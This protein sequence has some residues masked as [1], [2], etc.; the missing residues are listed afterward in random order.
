[1]NQQ[2]KTIPIRGG[3]FLAL[4]AA[5][6]SLQAGTATFDLNTDPATGTNTFVLTGNAMW[7]PTGGNPGGFLR[8]TEAVDSQRSAILFPDIDQGRIVKAFNFSMDVRSGD[9]EGERAADGFSIN[10]ARAEDPIIEGII[11]GGTGPFAGSQDNGGNELDLPEEGTQTG[12]GIG[13]DTWSGNG[14]PGSR[15][16]EGISIR[17][18][19]QQVA[20]FPLPTRHGSVDDPTSLQTGPRSTTGEH[21][22]ETL[23]WARLRVEL[24]EMGQLSVF[25]KGAQLLTNYQ[26]SYFPSAGR[27][28]FGGRTGGENEIADVDNIE[29]TTIPVET[30]DTTPPT[31]P[32]N[33]V[34]LPGAYR[35]LLTWEPSTD[36]ESRVAYTIEK[37][38]TVLPSTIVTNVFEDFQVSP[39]S[40]YTYRIRA[41]DLAA[42]TSDWAS[43][44]ANTIAPVSQLGFV[45][46]EIYQNIPGTLVD[47]LL[48]DPEFQAGTPDR[49]VYLPGLSFGEW[50]GFGDTYGD[51]YGISLSGTLTVP[52]TGQYNFFIRSDDASRL[53]LNT[54]GAALPDPNTATPIAEETDCCDPFVEP[55]ELNDDAF[56]SPTT[57]API[58]LTAGSNY[59]FVY[60]VKEGGGGDWGQVAM[61]RV[62]DTNPAASLQPIR[63]ALVSGMVDPTGGLITITSQPTNVTVVANEPF[64]L[65]VA[66]QGTS[67]FGTNISYQW[68]RG[69][70]I[71]VGANSPTF[72][73]ALANTNLA[74]TYSVLVGVVGTNV[75]SSNVTVTV[76]PDDR[77]PSIVSASGS[78]TFTNV[79]LRFSEPV[80][81][82][83]ATTAGNYTLSG[84]ATVS[85]ARQVDPYTI[86]LT[87]SRQVLDTNYTV[88]VTG[89]TDLAGNQVAANTTAN[90]TSW[91]L[92]PNRAK[93]EQWNNISGTA[94][95]GLLEDPEFIAGTPDVVRF[96]NG[97]TTPTTGENY[98]DNYGARI[99][100]YII[101]ETSGDYH[102]FLRS[103]DASQLY[104]NT[105]GTNF[106]VAGVDVP[107]A[108]ETG[109]CA[110][111]QEP[112]DPRTTAAP[113][114]LQANQMY[115][116]MV[117]LK[118][119][120]GGDWFQVAWRQ[121]NDTTAAANLAP[122]TDVVYMYGP[123]VVT[124]GFTN[125]LSIA[126]TNAI[127]ASSTNSPAAET[128]ERAIDQQT[129]T[130]YLNFD[131]INAGFTVTPG[132][133]PTVVK[134]LA[135]TSANDAPERD[136][137]SYRLEG[138][139]GGL[140]S[141]NF[142][143][144]SEGAV[145]AFS[146]RFARQEILFTNN[147]TAYTTY[148]ITFPTVADPG[149][150]NSMQ[151]AE[152]E[153]LG[154]VGGGGPG[155]T[156]GGPALNFTRSTN[157]MTITWTGTGTLETT[158]N[159]V[160]GPWVPLTG[161]NSPV[162][163]PF[164]GDRA[165]YRLRQ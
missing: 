140:N 30:T 50:T 69:T 113:I 56:T 141:T 117:L 125:I 86:E 48:I 46:G 101:P 149:A 16:L 41:T 87:T 127:I 52:E 20:Q 6:L 65:S 157:A 163:V 115:P 21:T 135:L 31:V 81:A 120:G 109:C 148:R 116:V 82:P 32:G 37:N 60:L 4:G 75:T 17:V 103:D 35:V 107:I 123:P 91:G 94:V 112:G 93:M 147:T 1:M 23:G 44:T 154:T 49:A 160:T 8:I 139:T 24:N 164:T 124:S 121:A 153:L 29:I 130:K 152:V 19:G 15:D 77:P 55:G 151:I 40:N 143:L 28:V 133:G 27:L 71:L 38:G 110:A 54:N 14:N 150:A 12:I 118:E 144:I 43:V 66:V 128:V 119:G 3:L 11:G 72:T 53:Y 95:I 88:T 100:A 155:P 85:A 80:V 98:G 114:T 89:V 108:E 92:V 58:S 126:D 134:G 111:F 106:P 104:L 7:F 76:L 36:A 158:T 162:T 61:R 25:W 131:E 97:L 13:F 59:G 57:T 138:S 74:G 45:R 22:G 156:N 2:T 68:Y 84:G 90:F 34:A 47:D 63:G 122:L 136:P 145:P 132:V 78:D 39:N 165:F 51:N 67:S 62:G 142:T 26:T 159:V 129:N 137:A 70:N 9:S 105:T 42:N 73:N 5:T 96:L 33:P 102:F 64:S 83:S 99:T 18:D 146:S 79:T 10:Y 161:S